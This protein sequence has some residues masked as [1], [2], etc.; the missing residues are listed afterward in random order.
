MQVL[1][2]VDL[3]NDFV[4]GSLGTK[5]AEAIVPKLE[6]KIRSFPGRVLFTRDTHE[7]DYLETQEGKHL[8]VPHCV[9]HTEGWEIHPTLE[10]LRT[11]EAVDKETF[12]SRELVQ[13]LEAW[14][15]EEPIES[16]ELAG[17]CTDICVISNALLLKAYFPEVPIR[18][19]ASCSAGVSP[20]SHTRA[21]EAMKVCQIEIVN[22]A[23]ATTA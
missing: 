9:R 12:G 11:T 7:E 4:S 5:E 18:V 2:V 23:D 17:L 1:I 21:L 13:V 10:A 16:I 3:Q 19:D 15:K 22:E 6:A 8:P 14:Q 20:E